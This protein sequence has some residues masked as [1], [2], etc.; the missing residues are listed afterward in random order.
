MSIHDVEELCFSAADSNNEQLIASLIARLSASRDLSVPKLATG[1]DYLLEA[2]GAS[3]DSSELKSEFCLSLA[4]LSPPDT[5]ILRIAVQKAF[6]KLKK[7]GFMKSAVVKASGVRDSTIS[8]KAAVEN[9]KGIESLAPGILIFNPTNLRFGEVQQLDVMTSVVII[10]WRGSGTSSTMTLEAAVRDMIFLNTT[11]EAT[12]L[13]DL[14]SEK[15]KIADE[16]RSEL[17]EAAVINL[18][19]NILKQMAV[20]IADENEVPHELLFEWWTAT[21]AVPK[22]PAASLNGPR[23]PSNARTIHELHTTILS[24]ERKGM[25]KEE[26]SALGETL[27][28]IKIR[29]ND[30]KLLAESLAMLAELLSVETVAEISAPIASRIPFWPEDA[31]PA[32]LEDLEPWCKISVKHL[33]KL[34]E[35]TISLFSNEYLAELLMLMPIRSWGAISPLAGNENMV[36]ALAH[37]TPSSDAVVWTWKNRAQLPAET[38]AALIPKTVASALD[39]VKSSPAVNQ[40]KKLFISDKAFHNMLLDN[41]AGGEMIEVLYAIQACDALKMDEKQSLLVKLSALSPELKKLLESGEGVRLFSA[42]SKKHMEQQ[43]EDEPNISSFRSL[44]IL[45]ATLQDLVTKQMPENAAAIAHAR[46]YGDLKENAEYKAAKERQAFLQ[47]RSDE[48]E[49]AIN[50]TLPMDFSV[51]KPEKEAVPGSTVTLAIDKSSSKETFHLLGA[52][53][54]DPDK[55]RVAYTSALGLVVK[56]TFIGEKIAMP[57]GRS[58]TLEDVAKLPEEL[59]HYLSNEDD[60][61]PE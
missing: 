8:P 19:D 43:K 59:L 18:D 24:Y 33:T 30:L 55:N 45:S 34:A 44:A 56:G 61:P 28:T 48:V 17:R 15:R 39:S 22:A 31:K 35:L 1:I 40:L 32:N 9:F 14:T 38:L 42:V 26:I 53:D 51:V 41:A 16:W 10:Q 4:L 11:Q 50:D 49:R 58:A 6:S 25:S 3:I 37:S 27:Q 7:S 57:D 29:E 21:V 54:G 13:P 5:P 46:S 20:V 2:W 36:A 52:W 12:S 47:R 60:A 23:H